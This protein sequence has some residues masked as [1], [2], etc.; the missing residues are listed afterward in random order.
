[1]AISKERMDRY[2]W[3]P[4]DIEIVKPAQKKSE[5]GK[6]IP[7]AMKPTEKKTVSKTK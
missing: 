7:K 3:K 2:T 4:G 5:G 1:M 6:T